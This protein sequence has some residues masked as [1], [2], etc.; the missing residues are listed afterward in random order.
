MRDIDRVVLPEFC[1]SGGADQPIFH[2]VV[3]QLGQRLLYP[4][5]LKIIEL[6]A[7]HV[8]RGYL[9]PRIQRLK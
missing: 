3:S 7:R 2:S 8:H 5:L 6:L 4:R 1:G 9:N